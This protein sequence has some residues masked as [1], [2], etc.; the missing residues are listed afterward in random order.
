MPFF[1]KIVLHTRAFLLLALFILPLIPEASAQQGG[2]SQDSGQE[3]SLSQ[4][5]A[6]LASLFGRGATMPVAARVD[7]VIVLPKAD[8]NSVAQTGEN[9]VRRTEA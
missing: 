9:G 3:A 2:R 1:L 7:G 6:T 4:T 8:N 5:Q